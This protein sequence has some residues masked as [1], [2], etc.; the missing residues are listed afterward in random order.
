MESL[1]R[2]GEKHI[3]GESTLTCGD[4]MEECGDLPDA[5]ENI[6]S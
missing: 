1:I 6:S 5:G 3:L 4:D 2:R